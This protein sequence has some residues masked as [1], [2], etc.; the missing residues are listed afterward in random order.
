MNII[1]PYSPI[2][3]ILSLISMTYSS[4]S[5]DVFNCTTNFRICWASRVGM[6]FWVLLVSI[7]W[8][9]KFEGKSKKGK[10]KFFVYFGF[11]E[12]NEVPKDN[13]T[14]FKDVP[15]YV[16]HGHTIKGS[17]SLVALDHKKTV[18]SI[19]GLYTVIKIRIWKVM[20]I[21][22]WQMPKRIL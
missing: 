8:T 22:Y 2:V 4:N 10:T 15:L 14:T 13:K 3:S 19:R 5:P 11:N 12:R 18:A 1:K 7:S 16:S 20:V 6:Y 9:T 17:N 21:S